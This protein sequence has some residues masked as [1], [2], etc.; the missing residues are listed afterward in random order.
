M[1]CKACDQPRGIYNLEPEHSHKL[2][3]GETVCDNCFE[4]MTYHKFDFAE[5]RKSKV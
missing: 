5:L 2:A 4:Y 1:K 3:T